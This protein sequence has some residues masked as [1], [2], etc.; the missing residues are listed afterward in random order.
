M[1]P[2]PWIGGALALAVLLLLGM[3]GL[4]SLETAVIN[5]RRSRLSPLASGARLA[6]AE[7]LIEDPDDFQTSAHLAKSLGES[8]V[9]AVAALVGL[10]LA[11]LG[12]PAAFP[13]TV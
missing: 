9:Y 10:E 11:I 13:G 4:S 1:D 8:L 6:A 3:A 12:P 7:A 2:D 5:T